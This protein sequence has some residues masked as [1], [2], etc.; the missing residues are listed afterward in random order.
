MGVE[1]FMIT[2]ILKESKVYAY[3]V[4]MILKN[5]YYIMDNIEYRDWKRIT[6]IHSPC[7]LSQAPSTLRRLIWRAVCVK[8]LF[9]SDLTK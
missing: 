4:L 6:C 8:I 2:V 3:L 5:M 9:G 1:T 7:T